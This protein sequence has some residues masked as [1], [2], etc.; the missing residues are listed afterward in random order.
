LNDDISLCMYVPCEFWDLVGDHLCGLE[1]YLYL[2]LYYIYICIIY[3]CPI[4]DIVE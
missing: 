1:G 2:Y 3:I 4:Y